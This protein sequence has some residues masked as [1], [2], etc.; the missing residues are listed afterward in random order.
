MRKSKENTTQAEILKLLSGAEKNAKNDRAKAVTLYTSIE[1]EMEDKQD[2]MMLGQ[3]AMKYLEIAGRANDQILKV[4][5]LKHKI[6]LDV[7]KK[8]KGG[9]YTKDEIEALL[10]EMSPGVLNNYENDEEK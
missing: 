8:S 2:H 1:S 7:N 5:A 6:N 3:Q 4:V 10:E 9:S